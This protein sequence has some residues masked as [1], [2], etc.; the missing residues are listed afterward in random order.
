[1]ARFAVVLT[2]DLYDGGY[3]VTVPALPG[4]V[5]DGQSVSEALE[6]AREAIDLHL[7]GVSEERLAGSGA[8]FDLE[9]EY[10]DVPARSE[11]KTPVSSV[12]D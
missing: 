2:P 3:T 4:I 5:T 8:R 9:I 12:A 11:R 10:V 1:M 6:R 7:D